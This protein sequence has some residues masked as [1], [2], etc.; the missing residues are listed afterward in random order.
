[1]GKGVGAKAQGTGTLARYCANRK[2]VVP[3]S[4]GAARDSIPPKGGTTN[5]SSNPDLGRA[6]FGSSPACRHF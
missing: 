1:M 6:L 2:F 5:K 4:A 3:A